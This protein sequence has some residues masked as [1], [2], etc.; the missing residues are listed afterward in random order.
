MVGFKRL[1]IIVFVL[2]GLQIATAQ[3]S[4][5]GQLRVTKMVFCKEIVGLEPLSEET[6]FSN[7]T[8]KIFCFT[9]I[10]GAQ[11]DMQITHRWYYEDSLMAEVKLPVRSG[12][13]RTY[14]SKNIMED[15]I[16]NWRVEVVDDEGELIRKESFVVQESEQE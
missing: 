14:S 4:N 13:W 15:W 11:F 2:A 12:A 5:E 9:K 1:L 6:T 8:K 16:G 3:E 7:Q 10:E